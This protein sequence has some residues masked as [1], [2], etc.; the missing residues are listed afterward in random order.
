MGEAWLRREFAEKER[1]QGRS[2][3][4][5]EVPAMSGAGDEME[6][7]RWLGGRWAGMGRKGK[8]EAM[9]CHGGSACGARW[10][11]WFDEGR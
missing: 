10:R 3:T 5:G 11:G 7:R 6:C 4:E 9:G 8:S 2:K 1:K